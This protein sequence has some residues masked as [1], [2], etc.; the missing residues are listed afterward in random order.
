MKLMISEVLR[1]AHNAK[2]KAQ[3]I[4]ILQDNSTQTLRSMF[5]MNFD[6]TLVSRIPAGDVPYKPNEAPK[7][8]EH[9][10]LEKEGKKL[11]YYFKGG[12]DNLPALKIETMFIAL[13]EGLHADEAEIVVAAINKKLHKKY[14]I[15]QA[16]VEE[17]FPQIKWGNRGRP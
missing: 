5:I 17:A 4:K 11:Y 1:K 13:L 15:T 9:T 6:E 3:K 10:L 12:A 2:T 16:V 8:T 14:R 7:G